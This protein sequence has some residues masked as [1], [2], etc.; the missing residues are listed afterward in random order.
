MGQRDASTD[1]RRADAGALE[2][3]IDHLFLVQITVATQ[4]FDGFVDERREIRHGVMVDDGCYRDHLVE[5]ISLAKPLL[6]DDGSEFDVQRVESVLAQSGED[7][8]DRAVSSD[9][10]LLYTSP[11]P[12]DQR[13]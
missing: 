8:V 7:V 6:L 12:R 9:P 4:Q 1:R 3:A 5:W 13:G 10:C 11:S 2:E